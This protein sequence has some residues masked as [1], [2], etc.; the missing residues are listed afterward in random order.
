MATLVLHVGCHRTGST[1]IQ[2]ALSAS[3]SRLRRRGVL[4]PRA[5]RIT[6]AHHAFG[7]AILGQDSPW[8]RVAVLDELKATLEAEIAASQCHT[9]LV[10][11]EVFTELVRVA[12][13]SSAV[14]DRLRLFLGMFSGVRVLCCVRHQVP[15]LESMYRFDVAWSH[16]AERRAFTDYVR[17]RSTEPQFRYEAIGALYQ[18][19][20]P[21]VRAEYL[22]FA[23]AAS[24]RGVVSQFFSRAGIAEAYRGEVWI[25]QSHSRLG[26]LAILLRNQG[27]APSSLGRRSFDNWTRREFPMTR[28]SLYDVDLVHEVAGGF[29]EAN[30]E[31]AAVA[32]FRLDHEIGR[33]VERQRLAGPDLGAEERAAFMAALRR[34]QDSWLIDRLRDEI[35]A[36]RWRIQVNGVSPSA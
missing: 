16:T 25:N 18:S 35:H 4:Y 5:G 7:Y 27:L 9:V 24:G 28:E 13:A 1:S 29:V 20:R 31:F 11:S 8:G 10:S 33:F 21:D 6:Q 30:R 23:G 32:G 19:V 26:T 22:A 12:A 2:A 36:F 14:R 15:L 17:E 3:T 34:R